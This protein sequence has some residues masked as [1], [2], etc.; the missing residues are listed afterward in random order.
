MEER[1]D[2]TLNVTMISTVL[3]QFFVNS[4]V[5]TDHVV[6]AV[7]G[8]VDSTALLAA[9]SELR[10]D[11]WT[12]SAAHVNH[13]LR[14][15]ESVGDEAFVR[16]LCGKLDV[17]LHVGDGTLD[18]ALVSARG[19]EAAA[20]AVRYERLAAIR[21]SLGARWVA[22][23]HQKN[24]QAETVL[25]RALHGSGVSGL[26]AIRPIRDD[27]FIR[28]LLGVRRD[29][30]EAWLSERGIVARIDSSNADPRFLRNRL[31]PLLRE[32][33]HVESL[34]LL[35]AEAQ[36]QWPLLERIVDEAERAC[37]APLPEG[38]L[39]T[40][41]PDEIW[42]RAELLRRQIRRLDGSARDFDASRLS[43]EVETIRR[44][45]VTG[46]LELVRR[47][48]GLLLREIPAPTPEFELELTPDSPAF[49]AP[50]QTSVR[51]APASA[52]AP[53]TR[54]LIQLPPGAVPRFVVRN[55]RDGDRF[56]PLGLGG[57]KKLKEFLIDRKIAAD[58][59]DRLPLLLWNDEIVWIAGVEVSDRFKVTSPRGELYEVWLEGSGESDDRDESGIHG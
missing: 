54:Q 9:M 32:R 36:A 20:R 17:R 27:G 30:I 22:T 1:F 7:S 23:A 59:R 35:A 28:P 15:E 37:V 19:I 24:D 58:R 26:R 51:V 47:P 42:V 57:S 55:R 25:M 43:R 5:K 33:A 34:A 56:R 18:P 40:R 41:W 45:T 16:S 13:H 50:L 52:A 48:D 14:G 11:G 12:V 39:F 44:M 46:K 29:E 31:R 10:A 38:T 53:A 49:I 6:V 21:D 4:S 3:R 2:V 8:G